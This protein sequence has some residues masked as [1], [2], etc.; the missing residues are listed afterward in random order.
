MEKIAKKYLKIYHNPAETNDIYTYADWEEYLNQQVEI[1]TRI[2]E[3]RKDADITIYVA[4]IKNPYLLGL[5]QAFQ[6]NDYELLN[7]AIYHYSKHRLLDIK[8][9]GYDH[10]LYFWNVMDSMACNYKEAVEKCFPEE[11]G[12]CKNGYPFYVVASNLLMSLWYKNQQWMELAYPAGEKFLRQKKGLWEKA[13]VAYLM[14]LSKNDIEKATEALCDVCKYSTRLDRPKIYKC[15]CTEAQGLYQIAR[16]ILSEDDFNRIEMPM[17]DNFCKGLISWQSEHHYPEKGKMI[18]HYPEK[19]DVMNHILDLPLPRCIL[20]GSGSRQTI[21]T[22]QMK[23][24]LIA[25]FAGVD[26]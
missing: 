20:M 5:S 21:D 15:F 22:E 2:D 14:A 16:Y 24:N 6:N 3:R 26:S 8:A 12:L 1:G 11:L 10:C 23:K 19:L 18:V 9:G 17:N 4:L 7:N 25:E 13:I